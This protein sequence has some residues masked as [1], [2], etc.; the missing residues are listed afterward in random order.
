MNCITLLHFSFCFLE[1]LQ[2]SN[3]CL[4]STT[5]GPG[6][7][8]EAAWRLQSPSGEGSDRDNSRAHVPS[9]QFPDTQSLATSETGN[10]RSYSDVSR[11][12]SLGSIFK[13]SAVT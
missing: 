9:G 3:G 4:V 7:L 13:F 5:K 2:E 6:D 8:Q 12:T 11:N 10:S 1:H